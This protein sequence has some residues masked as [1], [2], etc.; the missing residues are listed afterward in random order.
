MRDPEIGQLRPSGW[1]CSCLLP[2]AVSRQSTCTV[3]AMLTVDELWSRN[4]TST[5]PIPLCWLFSLNFPGSGRF[6]ACYFPSWK[7]LYFKCL[8]TPGKYLR[9]VGLPYKAHQLFREL[10]PPYLL[11]LFSWPPYTSFSLNNFLLPEVFS[12]ISKL[13][14]NFSMEIS[15]FAKLSHLRK[16]IV[17]AVGNNHVH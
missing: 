15:A 7:P 5:S 14:L 6:S 17:N 13:S 8:L 11:D 16:S 12:L 2:S 9:Y 3:L 4:H 1:N 10:C